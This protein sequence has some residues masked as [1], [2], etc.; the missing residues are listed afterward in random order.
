M[1]DNT[2]KGGVDVDAAVVVLNEAHSSELAHEEIDASAR[3]ANHFRQGLLRYFG[4]CLVRSVPFA[5]AGKQQ[6]SARQTL[7]AGVAIGYT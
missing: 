5:I 2:Q 1:Q 4:K 6:K 3:G 7:F